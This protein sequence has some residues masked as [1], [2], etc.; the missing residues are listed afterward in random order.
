MDRGYDNDS[1]GREIERGDRGLKKKKPFL[2]EIKKQNQIKKIVYEKLNLDSDSIKNKDSISIGQETN[3]IEEDSTS[4][5]VSRWVS[6]DTIST[7]PVGCSTKK[8]LSV[9]DQII[10][11]RCSTYEKKLLI[12]KV[13]RSGL[14]LSEYFRRIAFEQQIVERLSDD[15]IEIYQML[16][17]YHNNF[18]AISNLVK[19]KNPDLSSTVLELANEL[20][21]HL[22][23]FYK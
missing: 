2:V 21:F 17:K 6:V 14:T 3:F 8:S 12:V 9:K 18:K 20:K 1:R 15:E 16:V 22:K 23:K 13:K 19:K 4:E 10:K 11:F 7:A 5:K